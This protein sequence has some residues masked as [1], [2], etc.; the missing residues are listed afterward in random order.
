MQLWK[1]KKARFYGN[2]V[3][4]NNFNLLN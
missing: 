1:F 2:I 3:F 4:S